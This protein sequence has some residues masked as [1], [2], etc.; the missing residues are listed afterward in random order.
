MFNSIECT[1]KPTLHKRNIYDRIENYN[2]IVDDYISGIKNE[3]VDKVELYYMND[4]CVDVC[5]NEPNRIHGYRCD[6][7]KIYTK[8][9]LLEIISGIEC[10]EE[11]NF[12][13]RDDINSLIDTRI[14]KLISYSDYK[15]EIQLF[16]DEEIYHTDP[17]SFIIDIEVIHS[18]G[19]THYPGIVDFKITYIEEY[20]NIQDVKIYNNSTSKVVLVLGLPGSGKTHYINKFYSDDKWCKFHDLHYASDMLDYNIYQ[21]KN[22]VFG[23]GHIINVYLFD[24]L[25]EHI[26]KYLKDPKKQIKIVMFRHDVYRCRI[27]IKNRETDYFNTSGKKLPHIKISNVDDYHYRKLVE[28]IIDL[29][30]D[31]K[32]KVYWLDVYNE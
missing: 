17:F 13:I 2:E 6:K 3:S 26:V 23:S 20:R 9:Y 28:W 10:C 7:I 21:N 19:H 14:H 16:D 18:N 5:V 30:L 25:L 4:N 22:I 31:E 15:Y 29:N 32:Y 24:K 1:G 12:I 8:H 11:T 27:N